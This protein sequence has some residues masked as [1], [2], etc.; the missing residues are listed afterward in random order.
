MTTITD[1]TSQANLRVITSNLM[2]AG[3]ITAA[4][5]KAAVAGKT[6]EQVADAIRELALAKNADYTDERLAS[7]AYFVESAMIEICTNN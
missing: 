6:P 3:K 4:N 1:L 2:R 7:P 5:F